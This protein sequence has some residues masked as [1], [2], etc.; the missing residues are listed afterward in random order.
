MAWGVDDVNGHIATLYRGILRENSDALFALEIHRIHDAILTFAL[1][2][3][4]S[5][6]TGLPE[7]CINERGLAMIDVGDNCYVS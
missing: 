6:S 1:F 4:S 2:L 5:E 3:V 7:H